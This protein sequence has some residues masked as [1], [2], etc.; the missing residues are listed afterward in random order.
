MDV[1]DLEEAL[2]IINKAAKRLRHIRYKTGYTKSKCSSDKLRRKEEHL[3][4]LKKQIINKALLEG[5]ANEV[6]IHSYKNSE[7][8]LTVLRLVRFVNRS[9]H[10]PID[11]N[12]ST[13]NEL[14]EIYYNTYISTYRGNN[15]STIK[16]KNV[17]NSYLQ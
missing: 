17:L 12:E 11:A 9:F 13:L 15:F 10:I 7:G 14:G 4:S 8:D 3:Y 16:A 1:I 5:V 2:Y 6:G